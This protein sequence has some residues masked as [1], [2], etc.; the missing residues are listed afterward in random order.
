MKS[1][2]FFIRCLEQLW[3]LSEVNRSFHQ[4]LTLSLA[5]R[6]VRMRTIKERVLR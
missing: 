5:G 1:R 2:E 4:D 6:D 3:Y